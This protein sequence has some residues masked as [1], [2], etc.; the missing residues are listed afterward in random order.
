MFGFRW[1]WDKTSYKWIVGTQAACLFGL[2]SLLVSLVTAL[3]LAGI[4][5]ETNAVIPNTIGGVLG[6]VTALSMFFVWGGMQKY[7]EMRELRDPE[8]RTKSRMI[9]IGLSVGIWYGAIIYYLLVYLPARRIL[10]TESFGRHV[11]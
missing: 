11:S 2:A 1:F 3:C 6:V 4:F 9:R 8:P 5:H 10:N 7:Q